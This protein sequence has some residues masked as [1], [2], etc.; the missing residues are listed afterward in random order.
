MKDGIE[1]NLRQQ[2]F[3][4]SDDKEIMYG[5]AAGGGKSI[6]L[7]CAAAQYVD[8]PGYAALILRRSYKDLSMPGALIDV[9]TQWWK[10]TEAR[11]KGDDHAWVFP[12][13]AQVRFGYI[14]H[15]NDKFNYQSSQFQNIGFDELTQ[16]TETSYEFLFSRLRRPENLRDIPLRMRSASNPGGEGHEWVKSRFVDPGRHDTRFI[17]AFL[18]D[19]VKLDRDAYE[20]SLSR[21]DAVTRNQLRHGDWDVRADGNMFKRGWFKVI[22]EEPQG[23]RW[24]RFWDLA[25]TKEK[26]GRDPDYTSS[27]KMALRNGIWFISHMTNERL[28]PHELDEVLREYARSDGRWSSIRM[29]QEPGSNGKI[30]MDYYTRNVFLGYDFKGVRST[31]SKT[32]RAKPLSSAAENGN[33]VLVDG[34]WVR[35]FVNQAVSFP[36][37][38]AHDDMVD[39]ASGAMSSLMYTAGDY[40]GVYT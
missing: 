20:E 26:E 21:L 31:G 28:S 14:E 32:D 15:E 4:K 12:T 24:T 1:K 22:A 17:P 8:Q 36:T 5:G 19:N 35:D 6:A 16:F 37:K 27:C 11:W 18:E 33:L 34:P 10:N 25:S 40:L 29:E 2:E 7:L 3:L 39:S 30:L 38:G 23:L 9:S 13:Q